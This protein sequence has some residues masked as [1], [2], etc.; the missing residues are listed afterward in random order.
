MALPVTTGASDF[1]LATIFTA[2]VCLV[3][4]AHA[5]G[6]VFQ[7]CDMPRVIGEIAG[8][9]LLGPSVMGH[10][11]PDL[12]RSL[13][14][15][16]PTEGKLIWLLY[17]IG[18]VLL[19]FVSGFEVQRSVDRADWRII[20]A[21]LIGATVLSFAAGVAA[22]A[23]YD[24]SPFAGPKANALSLTL[25]IAIAIAVTSIPVISR[26]FLDL[27]MMR[28]RFAKI[29]LFVATVEDLLL[30][31][32][33]SVALGAAGASRVSGQAMGVHAGI[34]IVFFAVALLVLP[35]LVRWLN[36]S[37]DGSS[38]V[39]LALMLCF[40]LAGVASLLGLNVVFGAL[41]AGIILGTV[42]GER[43]AKA[44][45][46]IAAIGM[47]F[48]IPLYFAIVGWKI[49][50]VH[51]FDLSFFCGFLAVAIV[52]KA[53]GTLL[54][55]RAA[56]QDWRSSANLAV[57]MNARGGPGIVVATVAFEA[58]IINETFFGILVATALITS[59][60]AGWWLRWVQKRGWPLLAEVSPRLV[61]RPRPKLQTA[62]DRAPSM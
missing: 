4:A 30:W 40:A 38:A 34:T 6:L 37:R 51:H 45:E 41:L 9:L 57:A 12:Y 50:L 22:P 28:T 26:I 36:R 17:W 23:F 1:E 15:A 13:F 14:A 2:V 58:Q 54:A 47:G 16:L 10:L 53:G 25:I 31:M 62:E 5:L 48:F 3:A 18:L 32:A 19:M 20:T 43:I 49:D 39:P 8:G 56:G 55:A 35:R 7:R 21:I 60:M 33:L 11:A 24:F 44:K 42:S 27:G 59:L 29:V 46:H 52:C 61:L